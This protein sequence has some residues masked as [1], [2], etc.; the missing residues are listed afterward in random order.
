LCTGV[1]FSVKKTFS[2]WWPYGIFALGLQPLVWWAGLAWY[3]ALSANPVTYLMQQSGL[4]SLR[5]L[6]VTLAIGPL[7]S[8]SRAAW[9]HNLR[10][11]FGLLTFIYASLHVLIYSGLEQGFDWPFIV[12]EIRARV[13][14]WPG[15]LGWS[16][17]LI[18]SL[19][20]LTW[21]QQYRLYSWK[22]LHALIYPATALIITHVWWSVRADWY[23]P[24]FYGFIALLLLSARLLL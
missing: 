20:S 12:A 11:P 5:W 17:L 8:L 18:L 3:G 1:H 14:L 10:R 6:C 22:I 19:T 24:A 13:F 16:I 21:L 4:W 23:E 2:S 9:L 7:Y 15:V